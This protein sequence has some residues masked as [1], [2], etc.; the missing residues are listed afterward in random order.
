MTLKRFLP[1]L[2]ALVCLAA[3][4]PDSKHFEIEGRLLNINQGDFY[5]YNDDGLIRGIDTIHVQGG[6]F[7]YEMECPHPTT[8]YLV[9]PNFSLQPIFAQPGK[10]VS[11]KGDASHLKEMEV[12]G[13]DDNELMT[14]FRHQEGKV[15]PPEAKHCAEQFI[16]AHTQSPVSVW[17]TRKYFIASP[18]PD[19]AKAAALVKMLYKN[20]PDNRELARLAAIMPAYGRTAVGKPLPEFSA[21]DTQGRT[22]SAQT[23]ST[24]VGLICTWASWS[25]DSMDLLRMVKQMQSQA[26]G[27]LKVLLLCMDASRIDAG[28]A[29][30]ADS[31]ACP[32]VCD[33]KMFKGTVVQRL[34]LCGVPDN[35]LLNNGRIV[36][37]NLDSN[38]LRQKL[39]D[40]L[41][42][43]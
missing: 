8:L 24:G 7:A 22:V 35:I 38:A 31:L 17:L 12:K 16:H 25:Y 43:R 29:M 36:A 14:Q 9:F 27:R 40:M 10:S 3:C 19:M 20:Q 11:I 1:L 42:I 13:T 32:N 34:G 4:G 21:R 18:Q 41:G 33:G 6:R 39:Q 23:V 5:I 15:T 30:R 37:R 2:L 26:G 28:N